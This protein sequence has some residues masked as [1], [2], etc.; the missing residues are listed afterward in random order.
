MNYYV[1][2]YDLRTKNGGRDDGRGDHWY[3]SFNLGGRGF[4]NSKY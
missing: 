1:F 3:D 2:R 4:F